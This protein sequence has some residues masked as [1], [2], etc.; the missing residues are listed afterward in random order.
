MEEKGGLGYF[1]L[2]LGIGA[3]V[4][5]LWAP[6]AGQE[7]RQLIADRA[8][9]GAEYLK[10][11]AD[12]SRQY[13]QQRASEGADYVRQRTDDLRSTASDMYEK[14]RS[15]VLKQRE[16]LNAAVEAGKQA[17]RDAVSDVRSSSTGPSPAGATGTPSDNV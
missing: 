11:R 6:R 5:I 16:N 2:G 1:L 9:E 8:G 14:G 15:T 3:A 10:N 4:G 12:E 17:Y 7:T 13:L